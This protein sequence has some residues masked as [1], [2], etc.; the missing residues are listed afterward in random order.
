LSFFIIPFF[1]DFFIVDIKALKKYLVCGKIRGAAIDVHPE[2]PE[3]NTEQFVSDLQGIPNVILTPH[4]GGSTIEAQKN[5]AQ[6]VAGKLTDYVGRGNT[7]GSVNFPNL[8][9]P[10]LINAH[11]LVH[12]HRNVPG[13]LAE[14]NRIFARSGINIDGQYLKTNQE[15]GYVIT[16]IYKTY[17]PDVIT[18]LDKIEATV[19]LKLLY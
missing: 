6:F 14:I 18:E 3:G 7:V 1:K 12:I 16:D 15:I 13:V 10:E 11:R 8:R 17:D 9:L 4:I 5:I 19:R 2:E